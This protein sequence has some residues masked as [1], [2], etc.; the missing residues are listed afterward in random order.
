[1]GELG[2]EPAERVVERHRP[3]EPDPGNAG[4]GKEMIIAAHSYKGGTG[5]T[6]F[7]VNLGISLANRGK[8]VCLLDLDFRAPSLNTIFEGVKSECWLND[9]LNQ[10]CEIDEVLKDCGSNYITNGKMF[11]GFANP[12]TCAIRDMISKDRNWEMKALCTLLSLKESLLKELH[13][14]YVIFDTSPGLQHNSINAIVSADV[15]LV[16]TTL[17]KSDVEGTQ[18]MINDLYELFEKKTEIIANKIPDGSLLSKNKKIKR[19]CFET[20]HVP[21][22][23]AI[24]CSCD[25]LKT[26][27][28]F[29][30]AAEKP[31]HPFTKT[32]EKIATKIEH[33]QLQCEPLLTATQI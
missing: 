30:L 27:G 16:I 11:V 2:C 20:L 8:K 4:G 13:F 15:I 9:Y 6:L 32:L 23:G 19:N 33:Q 1:L 18:R 29:F 28:K 7:S 24:P 17:E 10:V 25:I 22:I 14:D 31:N 26:K 3:F 12:S 5:K 21:M